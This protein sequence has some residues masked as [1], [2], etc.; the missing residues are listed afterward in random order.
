MTTLE[1]MRPA[2]KGPSSAL[3]AEKTLVT[4]YD[5]DG[6]ILAKFEFQNEDDAIGFVGDYD[7]SPESYVYQVRQEPVAK[8]EIDFSERN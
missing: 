7:L 3:L 8:I 2:Y 6:G 5:A 4:T 1:S